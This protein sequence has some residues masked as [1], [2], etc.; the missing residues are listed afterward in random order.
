[1]GDGTTRVVEGN[2]A[3]SRVR[4]LGDEITEVRRRLDTLVVELD[5]RRHDATNWKRHLRRH[6][7]RIVIGALVLAAAVATP[8]ATSR[9]R[10]RRRSLLV[11]RAADLTGKARRLGQALGRIARDPDRLASAPRPSLPRLGASTI[12]AL[13][14]TVAQVVVT[15]L[16]RTALERRRS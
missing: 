4:E 11:A 7:G 15:S 3:G 12:V 10:T 8:V 6:G 16:L 14:L 1:M 13:A 2:G 5:R 9:V